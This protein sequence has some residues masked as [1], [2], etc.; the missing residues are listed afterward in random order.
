V[1]RTVPLPET[2]SRRICP[3]HQPP[4]GPPPRSGE[5]FA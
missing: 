4:A 3:L 5:D 1:L 2:S